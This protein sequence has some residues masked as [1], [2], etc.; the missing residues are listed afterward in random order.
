MEIDNDEEFKMP[1]L[2]ELANTENWSFLYPQIL[3]CGRVTYPP[4]LTEEEREAL[5]E[6]DQQPERLATINTAKRKIFN[7]SC[8]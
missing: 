5:K 8:L 7:H 1:E 6:T 2:A 3:N 4:E